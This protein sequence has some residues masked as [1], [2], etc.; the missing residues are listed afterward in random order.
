MLT[1][2]TSGARSTSRSSPCSHALFNPSY[3]SKRSP[4]KPGSNKFVVISPH[5]LT[6]SVCVHTCFTLRWATGAH[7]NSML[8]YLKMHCTIPPKKLTY[9]TL[10]EY[11]LYHTFNTCSDIM[12]WIKSWRDLV[13]LCFLRLCLSPSQPHLPP[14]PAMYVCV[15]VCVDV[16]RYTHV[17]MHMYKNA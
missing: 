2:S 6:S 15:C 17:D 14:P 7:G 12:V 3:T 16:C 9:H 8:F 13:H 5:K 1:T 11:P 4:L 10:K